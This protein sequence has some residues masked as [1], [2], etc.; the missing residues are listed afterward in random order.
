MSIEEREEEA[1]IE[2]TKEE[3]DSEEEIG[4]TTEAEEILVEEGE[5]VMREEE[6]VEEEEDTKETEEKDMEE[7][8]I[9]ISR[10]DMKREKKVVIPLMR[11]EKKERKIL[12]KEALKL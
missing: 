7:V 9:E 4:M 12:P 6:V 10:G 1:S 11:R 8:L 2:G 3:V 5:M